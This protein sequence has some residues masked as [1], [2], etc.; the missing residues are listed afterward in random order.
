MTYTNINNP[1]KLSHFI[2]K[3]RMGKN[4]RACDMTA[5]NGKDSEFILKNLNPSMLY[6]FDIQKQAM[7][8]TKNLIGDYPNFKFILDSH[9]NIDSYIDEK[10][11]LFVYNLGFLPKGD[12]SIT[13]DYKTVIKSLEKSLNLL[14]DKGLILICLYPGHE[15]GRLEAKFI[16][17]FLKEL[18][19]K[20]YQVI[21]YDFLNQINNPPYLISLRK[22]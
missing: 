4:I 16:E 6:C 18:D 15:S 21:K 10:I 13:T 11:D 5:G 12:K 22:L 8:N 3:E 1:V 20:S 2:M 9:E 17:K 14:N 7:T 19:Q